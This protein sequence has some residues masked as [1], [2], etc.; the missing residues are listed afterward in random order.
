MM[1]IRD[2]TLNDLDVLVDFQCKLAYESEEVILDSVILKKGIEAMFQDRTRGIYKIAEDNGK[3]VACHMITYEWS[4]WRNGMIWWLQSVYVKES[5][6]KQGVFKMMYNDLIT[7]I[8]NDPGVIGLR[9][10]V[11]K[12]NEQGLKTYEAMGMDGSHYTV[13]EWMK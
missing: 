8:K 1:L 11:D 3:P 4:D 9:L 2:A 10:Y 6:R 5:H 7:K 12:K 13:Y